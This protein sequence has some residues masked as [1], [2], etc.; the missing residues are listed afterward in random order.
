M[1]PIHELTNDELRYEIAN[2]LGWHVTWWF[3]H[4]AWQVTLN[5]KIMAHGKNVKTWKEAR[6][7]F[8]ETGLIPDWPNDLGAA[9]K[10]CFGIR[11]SHEWFVT[12][13]DCFKEGE[14][15]AQ[16]L[17][18]EEFEYGFGVSSSPSR[19]LSILALS[20][21][22]DKDKLWTPEELDAISKLNPT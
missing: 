10:L 7:K 21:L 15:V 16:F 12:I 13:G 17:D 2:T 8:F 19:A 20:I 18:G 6:D 22:Q 4:Y 14:Y 1:K 9:L 5:G 11:P 3:N